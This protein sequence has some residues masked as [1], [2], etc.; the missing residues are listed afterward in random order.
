M[1][2]VGKSHYIV[3]YVTSDND[4][5]DIEDSPRNEPRRR[6]HNQPQR[7]HARR[8]A[9]DHPDDKSTITSTTKTGSTKS[10]ASK[11]TPKTMRE[12]LEKRQQA[13]NRYR[14]SGFDTMKENLLKDSIKL[15]KNESL[16]KMTTKIP[17][18]KEELPNNSIDT[19]E[20][21]ASSAGLNMGTSS[22]SPVPAKCEN[23]VKQSVKT[24]TTVTTKT[25]ENREPDTIS[26]WTYQGGQ[27]NGYLDEAETQVGIDTARDKERQVQL[28]SSQPS[29]ATS[30]TSVSPG[31]I[32]FPDRKPSQ[33]ASS[34]QSVQVTNGATKDLPPVRPPSRTSVISKDPQTIETTV[35]TKTFTTQRRESKSSF[36][37][38]QS[39]SKSNPAAS[40]TSVAEKN[41]EPTFITEAGN[42]T[43]RTN[44]D[45][46]PL[47]RQQMDK[48]VRASYDNLQAT[49]SHRNSDVSVQ[50]QP[51]KKPAN[52]LVSRN[53]IN[54]SQESVTQ[55]A[56]Q[57]DKHSSNKQETLTNSHVSPTAKQNATDDN[58]QSSVSP[59][60]KLEKDSER[61]RSMNNTGNTQTHVTRSVNVQEHIETTDVGTN[62]SNASS[63]KAKQQSSKK[64]HKNV[65]MENS[66]VFSTKKA[67]YH[68]KNKEHST[69]KP[70]TKMDTSK[71]K[72]QQT[73]RSRSRSPS[74]ANSHDVVMKREEYEDKGHVRRRGSKRSTSRDTSPRGRKRSTSRSRRGRKRS[75]SKERERKKTPPTKS[76]F[77]D[78]VKK[79]GKWEITAKSTTVTE[80]ETERIITPK[81]SNKTTENQWKSLVEK[82][83]RQPSPK[84]GKADD[85]SLLDS[86]FD[87]DDDDDMDIFKRASKRY[88]LDDD[89]DD[90]LV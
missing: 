56:K 67:I 18:Q 88:N 61:T 78:I 72:K 37:H 65:Q 9:R 49:S 68:D 30:R 35:T 24:V 15:N 10:K 40:Q 4:D 28:P 41:Q 23:I 6:T 33:R 51:Y 12:M 17:A 20:G 8:R 81:P 59:V 63:T 11:Q 29:R 87:D 13:T 46:R 44:T 55:N 45:I 3:F 16:N 75:V 58:K 62:L 36:V 74:K 2:K 34:R 5:T 54:A 14:A 42:D 57:P 47:S 90:S 80:E 25:T 26:T 77:P 79:D 32:T 85:R 50:K 38:E 19:K 7:S 76:R 22:S 52:I 1:S 53:N 86:N 82:Y 64:S 66:D 84:I 43:Q 48:S 69:P 21:F 89:D 27:T 73:R 31:K 71:G 70:R 60:T 83:I 39:R